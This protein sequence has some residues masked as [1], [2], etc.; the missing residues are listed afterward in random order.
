[1]RIYGIDFSSTPGPRKPITLAA[2]DLDGDRLVLADLRRLTTLDRFERALGEPGPWVA[3]MD[4]PFGLPKS[5]VQGLGW[6]AGWS[7]YVE[8]AASLGKQGYEEALTRL[9]QA[10]PAGRKHPLRATDR[11][12]GGLSPVMLHGVP[13]AKM[14]F[15]GAP[16]L[17]RTPLSI[18]PCRPTADSRVV[19]EAY[20]GCAARKLL[21]QRRSYKGEGRRQTAA[22]REGRAELL[23]ALGGERVRQVY[24]VTVEINR[25]RG[26]QLLDDAGGDLLDALLA[27]VQAAWSAR[28]RERNWGL[29]FHC[30]AAEGWIAD[31]AC[32]K[33]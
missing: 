21:L 19:L 9:R 6:P 4:F 5:V 8:H 20:P 10:Q 33:S 3:A 13:L 27:A 23:A 7:D 15:E 12:A 1:M 22:Q 29:P 2:C 30:D 31:P 26:E 18:Q 28:P 17:L 24:G 16:R 14:F 25:F 11:L 32:L